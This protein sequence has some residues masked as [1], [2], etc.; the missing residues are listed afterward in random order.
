MPS[1]A[2]TNFN[3]KTSEVREIAQ[4]FR[5]QNK[6][7]GRTS[8]THYSLL[9]GALVLLVSSWEVYCED[10]CEQAVKAIRDRESIRFDQLNET[11][12]SF[13][14]DYVY[15][16]HNKNSNPL[17]QPIAKLPDG[18]WRQLLVERCSEYARDFNTPK[19]HRK[20]GKNLH[21]MF[22]K[23]LGIGNIAGEIGK[24]LEE[25]GLSKKL[26][27]VVNLRNEIAHTGELGSQN[28]L[29]AEILDNHSRSF[30]EAAAAIDMI[31]RR[32]FEEHFEFA[33][34]NITDSYRKVL[35]ECAKQK[36][37]RMA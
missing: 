22:R 36:L 8:S 6:G 5:N 32:E 29:S 14:L 12:Q 28:R 3:V 25:P 24:F 21:E 4:V 37:V 34:W 19:F 11:L 7:V 26:D 27:E 18:G 1:Q 35:R 15:E 10:V 2:F 30:A 13:T 17:K 9:N 31:V 16:K 33:V 23:V 20:D